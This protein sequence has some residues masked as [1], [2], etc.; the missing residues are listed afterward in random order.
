METKMDQ[1]RI[2]NRRRIDGVLRNKKVVP[3]GK[4]CGGKDSHTNVTEL[5]ER[6]ESAK[7]SRLSDWRVRMICSSFPVQIDKQ[8]AT[9]GKC[10][11]SLAHG[12]KPLHKL[13]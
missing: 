6:T 1:L 3:D 8:E 4:A 12:F 10:F 11:G 13:Q 7:G 5:W 2:G 9:F